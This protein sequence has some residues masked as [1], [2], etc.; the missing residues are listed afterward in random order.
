MINQNNPQP[1]SS[2]I[3]IPNNLTV[4]VT[5]HSNVGQQYI[6]VTEDKLKLVLR[7]AK[8]ALAA[9]RDW[10]T[11]GGLLISFIATL[12]TAEFK[13]TVFGV[14]PS[15]WHALFLVLTVVSALFLVRS[16][17]LLF[18]HSEDASIENII[19]NIKS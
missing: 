19:K 2:S 3:N 14:T 9:Q 13:E 7:D 4:P 18:K 8:T 16:L 12:S 17:Y 6:T 1:A 5:H 11:P 10:W 15:V